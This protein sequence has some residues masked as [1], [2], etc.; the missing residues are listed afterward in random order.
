LEFDSETVTING[1]PFE[2]NDLNTAQQIEY[3]IQ[4]AMAANPELKLIMIQDGSLLD[5]ETTA[6]I[7]KACTEKGYQLL[8]ERV[9]PEG[10]ETEL[11]FIEEELK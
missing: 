9:R 5:N 8:I 7:F 2:E 4:I 3:G 1:I 11:K 6:N 10:G